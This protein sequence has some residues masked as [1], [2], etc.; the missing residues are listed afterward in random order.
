MTLSPQGLRNKAA[1]EAAEA[2]RLLQRLSSGELTLE[3]YR[4][5]VAKHAITESA[6]EAEPHRAALLGI[7]DRYLARELSFP[8][9]NQAYGTYFHAQLPGWVFATAE[10]MWFAEVDDRLQMTDE[11][12][13]APQERAH[14]IRSEGEFRAWLKETRASFPDR[15]D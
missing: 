12:E 6:P 13:P 2:L 3:Q 8:A 11:T 10:F 7:I 15:T 5:L 4:A 9:F 1:F 14:G